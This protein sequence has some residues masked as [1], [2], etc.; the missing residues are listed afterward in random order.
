MS[1]MKTYRVAIIGAGSRAGAHVNAYQLIENAGVVACSAPSP[2]R[3]EPFAARYGIKAYADAGEMIQ[4]EKPDLVHIVT[5]PSVRESVMR[6]VSDCGVQAD[7][8]EK[9]SAIVVD[10]WKALRRLQKET[11]TRFGVCHQFRWH[12]TLA[13]CR[14][15]LASGRLGK[16][17]MVEA[18]AGMDIT[19]QGT[20]ALHY[21]NSLNGDAEVVRVFGAV[22]GWDQQDLS[23]PGP[24]NSLACLTFDN[25]TRMFW[26]TGPLAPRAGDPGTVWQ[27]VRVAGFAEKGRV[28]WEEFG[29][30]EIVGPDG[31]E[32]GDY[33]GMENWARENL[34]A[35]AGFHRD[36]LA[37]I[38]D[39]SRPVGTNLT[40][41]LH[42][43]NAV[44]ALYASALTRQPVELASF[45]PPSDLVEKLKLALG[46]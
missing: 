36:M 33:G 19:N 8:F 26:N 21:G 37:W 4:Q 22:S 9:Q 16:L 29:R 28:L 41:S 14:E 25:G 31:A 3:R 7:T 15:A 18:T 40:R 34:K 30:W 46:A 23:H 20:H 35:Q 11:R 38:E 5:P 44:L 6:L 12:P 43:W 32:G 39:D 27:H 13:R 45:Y 17:L 42:E 1:I 2:N 10:D 24:E